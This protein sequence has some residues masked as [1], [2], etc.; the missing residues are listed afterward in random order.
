VGLWL[1]GLAVVKDAVPMPTI[2]YGL[3][4]YNR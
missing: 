1:Q 4:Q 2:M 3:K